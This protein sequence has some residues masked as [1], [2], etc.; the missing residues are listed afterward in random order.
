[1]SSNI[2]STLR[3]DDPKTWLLREE[4]RLN[5]EAARHIMLVWAWRI[6]FLVIFLGG[7]ELSA[8]Q[9]WVN[10]FFTSSPSAVFNY[11]A[12]AVVSAS[13]WAHVQ[14]TLIESIVS[15]VGGSVAAVLSGFLLAQS[16]IARDATRPFL[17]ILNSMPRIALAPLLI[18]WFGLGM[19]SKI[20]VGIS[21]TYFVVLN[22]TLV[23]IDSVDPDQKLLSRQLGMSRGEIFRRITLPSSVVSIFAG[24]N[25]GLVYG[26]LGVVVAEMLAAP[27]GLG[28]LIQYH[29]GVLQTEAVLGIIIF[30]ALLVTGLVYGLDSLEKRLLRW[31]NA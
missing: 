1:M 8:R 10:P 13:F 7:W 4:E 6:G 17:V 15:F 11:L 3:S 31:R 19:G 25:L 21:L 12:S 9:G 28:H 27:K 16:A 30:L 23:G 29:A 14:T 26:V 20:A 24:L 18:I 22:A 2:M 5:A